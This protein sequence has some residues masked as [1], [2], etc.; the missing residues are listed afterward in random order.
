VIL[1]RAL[2]DLETDGIHVFGP[3]VDPA[4]AHR[5]AENIVDLFISAFIGSRL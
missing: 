2:R 4:G 5:V 1:S 3:V